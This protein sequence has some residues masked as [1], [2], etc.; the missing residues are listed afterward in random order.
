MPATSAI[1]LRRALNVIT[2]LLEKHQ[3][4]A[5]IMNGHS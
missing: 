2:A 3:S 4:A 5:Q 1:H